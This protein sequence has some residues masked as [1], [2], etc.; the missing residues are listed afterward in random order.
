M[1]LEEAEQGF[2][3]ANREIGFRATVFVEMHCTNLV[4]T[5]HQRSARHRTV[6]SRSVEVAID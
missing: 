3:F 5:N 4:V 6:A 1:K 2:Q